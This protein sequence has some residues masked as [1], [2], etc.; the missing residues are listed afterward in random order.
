MFAPPLEQVLNSHPFVHYY[1]TFFLGLPMVSSTALG[2]VDIFKSNRYL[3]QRLPRVNLAARA[4][5]ALSFVVTRT[6]MWPIISVRFWLDTLHAL[7][8]GAAHSMWACCFYLAANAFL[9]GLQILWTGKIVKG[10]QKALSGGE[11][12]GP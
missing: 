12:K 5:F 8:S 10:M 4:A 9:T 11:T 6:V 7:G 2:V 3:Q 1:T